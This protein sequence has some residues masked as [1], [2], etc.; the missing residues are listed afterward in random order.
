MEKENAVHAKER[1]RELAK[2]YFA[3]LARLFPVMCSSDEFHFLPRLAAPRERARGFDSLDPDLIEELLGSTALLRAEL[4]SL[5]TAALGLEAEIDRQMILS[6]MA[7]LELDL[8][9]CPLFRH[10]PVL[11]LKIAGIGL[12]QALDMDLDV[13]SA[14]IEGAARLLGQARANAGEVV[15]LHLRAAADMAADLGAYLTSHFTAA[16]EERRAKSPLREL[17]R[18]LDALRDLDASLRAREPATQKPDHGAYLKRLL[19]E[20]F[21]VQRG[22]GEIFEIGLGE[23]EAAKGELARLA[24]EVDPSSN[25]QELYW[26]YISPRASSLSLGELFFGEMA[27]LREFFISQ[28]L[29]DRETDSPP[30]IEETPLYLRS[31]RAAAS[32]AAPRRGARDTRGVFYLLTGGARAAD[33]ESTTGGRLAREYKFLAAHETYPGHHVLDSHRL[34]NENPVRASV[35]S[36]LFYEGWAT[37]AETLLGE[38]RY[39]TKPEERLA[40]LKRRAWRAARLLIDVG[41]AARSAT[42]EHGIGWLKDAGFTEGQAARQI[43]RYR[44]TRGYQLCYTL[45]CWEILRLRDKYGRAL[46]RGRFHRELLARGQMDFHLLDMR[47]ERAAAETGNE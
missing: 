21:M 14:R 10:E 34:R 25:W 46:G 18:V 1:V 13:L 16:L 36:P 31:V 19:N 39:V 2:E 42:V 20:R 29:V 26:G 5:D 43:Q 22:L 9:E 17:A 23:L 4:L 27:S 11:Y 3:H 47:L 44:L 32:Y 24:A 38:E 41:P 7:A 37:Y 12:A 6:S 45:G 8:K 33:G 28:G 35:E 15:E 30:R 40:G